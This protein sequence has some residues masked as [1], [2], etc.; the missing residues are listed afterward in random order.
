MRENLGN[1]KQKVIYKLAFSNIF[2]QTLKL[3]SIKYFGLLVDTC[4][5]F[6]F[7]TIFENLQ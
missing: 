4:E 5:Y 7:Y 3:A 1:T 6:F 2:Y